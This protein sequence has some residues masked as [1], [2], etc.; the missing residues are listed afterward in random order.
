MSEESK[1]ENKKPKTCQARKYDG[2][3]CRRDLYDDYYCIFHSRNIDGKKE[4]FNKEFKKEFERQ[5]K[6]DEVFDFSGFIFPDS[7]SFRREKFHKNT[8]FKRVRFSG[9]NTFFQDAVFSCEL[10][11]F[12]RAKFFGTLID[13]SSVQ[14]L[15]KKIDFGDVEFSGEYTNFNRVL[16]SGKRIHFIGATFSEKGI[17]G[18]NF[19]G[20][21]FEGATFFNAAVFYQKNI[22]FR[23]T[24]FLGKLTSFDRAFFFEKIDLYNSYFENVEGLFEILRGKPAY[25]RWKRVLPDVIRAKLNILKK[26]IILL[27]ILKYKLTFLRKV[28]Y[29]VVDFRFR[30]G[31]ESAIRYPLIKRM[32]QD[33]WFLADF[34]KQHK[35]TYFIWWLFADCGRSLL[36][37]AA[38]SLFFALYFALNY[39]LIYCAYTTAFKFEAL[40]STKSFWTFIYYSVVTFTTLGFGDIVPTVEWVQ[41]WV[42]A[43]VVLGY[44]MLGGLISI[45]AVKL[46][47]RS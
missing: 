12:Q 30:L 32:I 46:A 29:R 17:K 39:Y 20:A 19:S 26:P 6:E 43:E 10:I 47:R 35:K 28:K 31:E 45:F 22:N 41:R 44:I 33:E 23:N 18:T 2:S 27:D 3:V 24:E 36:R 13:F 25:L 34:K 37:W 4:K 21:K 7:V 1:P 9:Q 40:T 14:F 8:Y 38:W 42:M 11:D 15:A 5:K 16:F